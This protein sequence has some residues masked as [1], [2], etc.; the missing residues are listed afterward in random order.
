MRRKNRKKRFIF[1]LM[2][3]LCIV[4]CG[5]GVQTEEDSGV[6]EDEAASSTGAAEDETAAE[7]EQEP[8]QEQT[9]P[10]NLIVIDA[11]EDIKYVD[12]VMPT[13]YTDDLSLLSDMKYTNNTYV[14]QDGKVYYRRYHE[15]SYEDA[16][17][18]LGWTYVFH[19]ILGSKKEIVCVDADGEETL[20]FTDEGYGDIY[21]I[22]NRFY[23][24]DGE[25][26]EEDGRT[27]TENHLYSVD[28]QGNDRIDYGSGRILVVD[29]ERKIIIL[30]MVEGKRFRYYVMNYETGEKQ[31]IL[32]DFD[33]SID[34]YAYQ[35]GWLYYRRRIVDEMTIYRLCAVSLEG[36]QK[37]IIAFAS[38]FKTYIYGEEEDILQIEADKDRVYFLFGSY[39]GR[40]HRFQEGKLISIKL[41]GTDYKA[42]EATGD[43]FCLCHD[44]EKTLI[45]F[46]RYQFSFEVDSYQE[47]DTTVW[48]MDANLCYISDLPESV[49]SSYY[50]M[51]RYYPYYPEKK[52][53]LSAWSIYGDEP[54]TNIYAVLSDSGKIAR[55]V[56]NLQN[57]IEKWKPED[58]NKMR[59]YDLYYADG[60]LYFT[61]EYHIYDEKNSAIRRLHKDVYRLKIGEDKA[62]IL[63]SY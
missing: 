37:E 34:T 48:D 60:F 6:N 15:D 18:L 19:P 51:W 13:Q 61:L 1:I 47:Y 63:Y 23:M 56:M 27:Y 2:L 22:N 32:S 26:C 40:E 11:S 44:E 4:A 29:K 25:L 9:L 54:K 8:E 28:M 52:G 35:D 43:I 3:A 20:L 42:V 5:K 57:T 46:P 36:E 53:V 17:L 31:T 49:I 21:L 24:T 14:Y 59:Y 41:D 7:L 10:D 38:D 12:E 30:E 62:E 33:D 50:R 55:V 58:V 16:A 39:G 45:Y